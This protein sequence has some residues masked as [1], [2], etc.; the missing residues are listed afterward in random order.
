MRMRLLLRLAAMTSTAFLAGTTVAS[1]A[2]HGGPLSKDATTRASYAK[3]DQT[4]SNSLRTR[5]SVRA[6][7]GR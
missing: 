5:D 7:R 2:N 4:P 6:V 3:P 1:A